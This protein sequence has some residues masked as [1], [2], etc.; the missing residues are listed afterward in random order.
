MTDEDWDELANTV[1]MGIFLLVM[2]LIF[3]GAIISGIGVLVIALF[4]S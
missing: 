1:C 3:V 2:V 4:Y